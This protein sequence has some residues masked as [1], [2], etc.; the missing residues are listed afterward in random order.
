MWAAG[1]HTCSRFKIGDHKK[2]LQREAR[3]EMHQSQ[4]TLDDLVRD[5]A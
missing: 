3:V 5:A 1:Q 4:F 2:R